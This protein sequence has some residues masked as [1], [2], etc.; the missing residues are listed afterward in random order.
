MKRPKM[1]DD[2][3]ALLKEILEDP[4]KVLNKA[5]LTPEQIIGLQKRL[6]PYGIKRTVQDKFAIVSQTN[7]QESYVRRFTMTAM[8]GFLYQMLEEY[9]IDPKIRRWSTKKKRGGSEEPPNPSAPMDLL[10]PENMIQRAENLLEMAKKAKEAQDRV[11]PLRNKRL[12]KE[13]LVDETADPI[14]YRKQQ[15]EARA[16]AEAEADNLQSVAAMKYL[17][18]R[19]VYHNGQEADEKFD[20]V[21]KEAK[22]FPKVAQEIRYDEI[23]R[24]R[25]PLQQLEVPEKLVK[26]MFREFI[27]NWFEYNPNSHVRN[28]YDRDQLA[29]SIRTKM[30]DG[31]LKIYDAGDPDRL[32]IEVLAYDR[33][34]M[35]DPAF[36]AAEK[37]A[38]RNLIS[39]QRNYN[40]I[41]SLVRDEKLLEQVNLIASQPDKFRDIILPLRTDSDVRKAIEHIP[42]SDT[43]HRWEYYMDVNYEELRTVTECLYPEK[44]YFENAVIIYDTFNG[45]EKS[46][47]HWFGEFTNNMQ[48]RLVMEPSLI[49]VGAWV[50]TAPFKGNREKLEFLNKETEAVKRIFERREQDK[51]LG[52]DLMMH[53][54]KKA[55]AKN[56]REDGPDDP[57]L[58]KYKSEL[59]DQIGKLGVKNVITQKEKDYLEKALGNES[60]AKELEFIED[61]EARIHRLENQ[62]LTDGRLGRVDEIELNRLRKDRLNALEMLK[63]PEGKI[64]L[65]VFNYSAKK[66]EFKK[67]KFYPDAEAPEYMLKNGDQQNDGKGKEK[68][69]K[70]EP[71]LAPFAKKY[72]EQELEDERAEEAKRLKMAE[73][74]MANAKIEAAEDA[75]DE[76]FDD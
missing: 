21:L 53:K 18:I 11:E 30:T 4:D 45:D 52:K 44:P 67:T 61:L 56:I 75:E 25:I 20:E 41:C 71:E 6:N 22:K 42:P 23:K 34:K 55:K 58:A 73:E 32:P 17:F 37:D 9:E 57:G 31:Y 72:L 24:K 14:D 68:F 35:E 7:L 70:P 48:E 38:V 63:V 54:G 74:A 64:Q 3:D 46:A 47:G 26:E 36:T 69:V 13:L 1:E 40:T 27:N 10:D 15:E 49:Q 19:N 8:V 76:E 28:A 50:L 39:S 43:F 62:L 51:K 5:D 33:P 2:F 29:E 66:G 65:D 16:A 59:S 12:E 60:L